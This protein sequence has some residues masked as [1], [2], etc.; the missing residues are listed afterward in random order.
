MKIQVT[1]HY[2]IVGYLSQALCAMSTLEV[3]KI[4][5]TQRKSLISSIRGIY[6]S[7]STII[8]FDTKHSESCLSHQLELQ[9]IVQ[10]L[11]K[12]IFCIVIDE[13]MTIC[14][15]Y[16]SYW[17]SI[18]SPQLTTSSTILKYFGGNYFKTHGIITSLSDPGGYRWPT[19]F[20]N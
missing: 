13:G 5:P 12:N 1:Q 11:N 8:S 3:L 15:M 20:S 4:F 6:P 7:K 10:Y 18:G 16:L 17:K 19:T 2:S 14:I 9:I